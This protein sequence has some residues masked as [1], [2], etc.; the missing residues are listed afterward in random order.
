[1]LNRCAWVTDEP[2][3]IDYHDNEWGQPIYDEQKLFEFLILEGMQAGL[4]WITI[5]KKRENFRIAFDY[6]N[7]EKIAQYDNKKVVALL[8]NPGIIRNQ[9][10]INA[11]INNAKAYLSLKSQGINF[12]DYLWR[13][14]DGD[15]IINNWKTITAVPTTSPQAQLMAKDLKKQ[16]FK[17]VGETIC[18]AFM[19]A[20]GMVDDHTLDCFMRK[21]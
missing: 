6:F 17:F 20:V 2:I 11:V 1:M 3:Y 5:L 19:Q 14:V 21:K 18:Y 10:K 8:E 12:S 15:P 13:F 4:S 7:P 16:G 9:R